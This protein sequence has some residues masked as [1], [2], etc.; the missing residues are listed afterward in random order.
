[1]CCSS[2]LTEPEEGV[3]RISALWQV[4]QKHRGQ[5]GLAS[6]IRRGGQ[7]RGTEL[8]TCGIRGYVQADSVEVERSCRTP[9]RP[10]AASEGGEPPHAPRNSGRELTHPAK[11]QLRVLKRVVRLL[12]NT[13]TAFLSSL[14]LHCPV[15]IRVAELNL[16]HFF[17]K[18]SHSGVI[19]YYLEWLVRTCEP[20]NFSE[21]P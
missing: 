4:S 3:L 8:F 12:E 20:N 6:G 13:S 14:K 7:A 19:A 2:K 15:V 21:A 10:S 5:P 1:M 17:K 11:Y 16:S 18:G 9:G